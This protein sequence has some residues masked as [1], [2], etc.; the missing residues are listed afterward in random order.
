MICQANDYCWAHRTIPAY[1]GVCNLDGAVDCPSTLHAMALLRQG[2]AHNSCEDM[3]CLLLSSSH[4]QCYMTS[5][6]VASHT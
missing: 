3:T 2:H 4:S 6:A 5:S 1:A